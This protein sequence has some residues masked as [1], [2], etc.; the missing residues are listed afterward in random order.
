MTANQPLLV[1]HGRSLAEA[2]GL[3]LFLCDNGIDARLIEGDPLGHAHPASHVYH[4][5]VAVKCDQEKLRA[6]TSE[7]E[8]LRTTKIPTGDALFCYHCG[9]ELEGP[10]AVCPACNEPLVD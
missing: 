10:A 3:T 5:V 9:Q 7:W 2:K 1:Y 6:L 8:S 4:D